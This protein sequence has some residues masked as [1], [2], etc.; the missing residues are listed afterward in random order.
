[1]SDEAKTSIE[2]S[3]DGLFIDPATRPKIHAQQVHVT[4]SVAKPK[5]GWWFRVHS[6][7]ERE[8]FAVE[9]PTDRDKLYVVFPHAAHGVP[10]ELL[11]TK[12]LVAGITRQAVP[13]VWPL[14]MPAED[15]STFDAWETARE[16]AKLA[17]EHWLT[18]SWDKASGR[19]ITKKALGDF[20]EPQWLDANEYPFEKWI[21]IAFRGR[22]ISDV[23][24]VLLKALR[25]EE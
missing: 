24:H 7:Y 22:I 10:P 14:S 16:A 20:G 21:K 8:V 25:G 6:E 23:D 17:C 4:M 18:M 19:Y 12:L 13:F 15:G 2:G 11:K 5:K 9:D 3:L 1:M